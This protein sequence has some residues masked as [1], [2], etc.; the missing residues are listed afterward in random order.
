[1]KQKDIALLIVIMAIS[2]MISIF[3]SKLFFTI[4]KSRSEQVD[5]VPVITS[6][7]PIP[8]SRYFNSNSI[9]PTQLI[10]IGNS[11]NSTPFNT[12]NP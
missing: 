8:N 10:N 1:M 9:D 7:F 12:P 3:T 2:I 6:N 11:N 4:P 5:V